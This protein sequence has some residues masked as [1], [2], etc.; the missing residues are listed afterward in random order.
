MLFF[1]ILISATNV[2]FVVA[3][4]LDIL[5][6]RSDDP[7]KSKIG[8]DLL[9]HDLFYYTLFGISVFI[10]TTLI[11]ECEKSNANGDVFCSNVGSGALLCLFVICF[12]SRIRY[13]D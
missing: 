10:L 5:K 2:C 9:A 6:Y 13:R 12:L 8:K 7:E 1:N 3:L 4:V 11:T